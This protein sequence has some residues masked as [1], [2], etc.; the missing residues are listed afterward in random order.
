M[1]CF[2]DKKSGGGFTLIE[3][4][5]VIAIIGLLS[6]IVLVS[7]NVAREKSKNAKLDA[8]FNQI[9]K[10]IEMVRFE[11]DRVLMDVT[12]S[13]YSAGSCIG[14]CD[15]KC[16]ACKARMDITMQSLGFNGALVDPWGKYYSVDENELE[17]AGDPCRLDSLICA[18]HRTV[19][20]P[21][22]SSE[23]R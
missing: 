14:A 3:L 15:Y 23:C 22:Y 7:L 19:R 6:T 18:D 13:G 8:D 1:K 12:G 10:A 20:I 4:L 9:L 17:F 21:F 5:V 11:Q 2:R 16:D